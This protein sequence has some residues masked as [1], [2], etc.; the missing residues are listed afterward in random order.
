MAGDWIKVQKDTPDKPEVLAIA[1]RLDIDPDA[2]VGKLVRIWSWFDTHTID[3][4]AQSVTFSFVD[5]LCGVTGFAQK[6]ADVGWLERVGEN[7]RLPNFGYH[8]GQTAKTR[9]LGKNRAQTFRGNAVCN[10]VGNNVR[11][12]ASVT[13]PL[14]EKRRE[15][16]SIT[17]VI[18]KPRKRDV[19]KVERPDDVT[20][21]TWADFTAMRKA[22]R[23]PLTATALD[24]IKREADKAGLTLQDALHT[25]CTRG[26]RGFKAEWVADSKPARQAQTLSFAERDEL[27]RRKRWEEMTGRQWPTEGDTSQIIDI[28]PLE[29]G[30]EPANQSH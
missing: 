21:Q 27:E 5:R 12:D 26:W 8:N 16:I 1:S 13:K 10:A 19:A 28:N 25:C 17:N 11:N 6:V 20:E 4:N 24:G 2:V 18:D 14:P 3:G 7:L 15:D 30:H 29:I 9:A 22:N 23:A